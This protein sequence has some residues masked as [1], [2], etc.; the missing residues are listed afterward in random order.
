MRYLVVGKK[1]N[2]FIVWG[3]DKK[4][5]SL[6]ISVY[7]HSASL[8]MP[9]GDHRDGFFYPTLT[10]THSWWTLIFYVA[11]NNWQLTLCMLM[12]Y[13]NCYDTIHWVWS[14]VYIEGKH[15]IISNKNCNVT[16][17]R[18][19]FDVICLPGTVLQEYS[20]LVHSNSLDPDDQSCYAK[21]SV[22]CDLL[23]KLKY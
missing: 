4:N 17:H 7:H 11:L 8:V 14:I 23:W 6:A 22:K 3:W 13:S 16:S 20:L 2:P 10:V 19:Y 12:S 5:Q 15:V 1:K 9:I 21:I 18:R